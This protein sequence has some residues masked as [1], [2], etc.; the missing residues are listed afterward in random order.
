[1][2]RQSDSRGGAT[3]GTS[4]IFWT[5]ADGNRNFLY[6]SRNGARRKLDN[7]WLN[8]DEQWNDN[9]RFLVRATLLISLSNYTYRESFRLY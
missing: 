9:W 8:R 3:D 5:D 4:H 7:V 2:F 1:M 6:L